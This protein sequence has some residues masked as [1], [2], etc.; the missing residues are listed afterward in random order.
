VAGASDRLTGEPRAMIWRGARIS[1][2]GP[3]PAINDRAV[4]VG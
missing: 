3:R 2:R 1:G 4:F